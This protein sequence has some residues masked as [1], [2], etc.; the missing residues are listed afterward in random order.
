MCCYKIDSDEL[1][2][3]KEDADSYKVCDKKK[4]LCN[5][6]YCVFFEYILTFPDLLFYET[7]YQLVV[8]SLY[9]ND[10]GRTIVNSSHLPFLPNL[11]KIILFFQTVPPFLPFVPGATAGPDEALPESDRHRRGE[12]DGDGRAARAGQGRHHQGAVP[13]HVGHQSARPQQAQSVWGEYSPL[14]S[15]TES[16]G[17]GG[18]GYGVSTTTGEN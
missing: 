18:I 11:N 17:F 2:Q 8:M 15:E 5:Q 3:Q 7:V 16:I 13:G 14:T 10:N 9:S 6:S 12:G 4:H 1:R